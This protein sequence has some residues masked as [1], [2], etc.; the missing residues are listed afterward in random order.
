MAVLFSVVLAKTTFGRSVYAIGSNRLAAYYSGIHV[1][2]IRL[3][4][5]T[6]MGFM[7]GL[8]ALFLTS[9][10]YKEGVFGKSLT[11][12]KRKN[13]EVD[14]CVLSIRYSLIS[15]I[16][17]RFTPATLNNAFNER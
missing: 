1:Q 4:I 6:V 3:G 14:V 10:P 11:D 9:V 8:A 17:A 12:K 2:T 16:S 7:S 13:A 5:Y 15:S